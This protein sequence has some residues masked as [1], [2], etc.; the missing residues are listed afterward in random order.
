MTLVPFGLLT[1]ENQMLPRLA[2]SIVL[3]CVVPIVAQADWPQFRGSAG[4]GQT[5][6][7]LPLNWDQQ[8]HVTRKV[9]VAGQG[10]S[11]PS[12]SNGVLYLTA[13]VPQG[14][15]DKVDWDLEFGLV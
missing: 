4:D 5:A 7:K 13:A 10:W 3:L 9:A 2:L 6:V 14:E 8:T 12:L 11:S 15:G 1:S